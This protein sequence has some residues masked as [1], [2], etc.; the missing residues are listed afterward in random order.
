[1]ANPNTNC[2]AGMRCPKCGDYGPFT[3]RT[4]VSVTVSDDGTSDDGCDYEWFPQD[5]CECED[6]GHCAT[7]ADFTE[8]ALNWTRL[9][10]LA[11]QSAL[12]AHNGELPPVDV[13]YSFMCDNPDCFLEPVSHA[14][15]CDVTSTDLTYGGEC[16][17]CKK[18]NEY[19]WPAD[20]PKDPPPDFVTAYN[21]ASNV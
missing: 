21:E 6:C 14:D 3:I 8:V 11:R 19:E 10:A 20:M 1:M 13:A 2:L 17:V 7:V 16:P 4:R 9:G 15:S 12:D 18:P 5:P